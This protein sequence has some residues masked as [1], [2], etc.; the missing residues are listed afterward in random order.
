MRERGIVTLPDAVRKL[1]SLAAA[2]V[3]IEDRGRIEGGML[4]DLVL[5]D[6][7]TVVDRATLE[8][9]AAVSEGISVVWVN[10]VMVYREG[11]ATGAYPGRVVRR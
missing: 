2:N 5:F 1:S 4:A 7:E 11:R 10:G 3:G 6:P 8:D 9:P